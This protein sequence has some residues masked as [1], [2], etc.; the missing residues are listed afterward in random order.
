MLSVQFQISCSQ[1]HTWPRLSPLPLSTQVV[2]TLWLVLTTVTK[3]IQYWR[4]RSRGIKFQSQILCMLTQH[5]NLQWWHD[6]TG[7][8]KNRLR[9]L[10]LSAL[11]NSVSKP[12]Q[13][14][15][16]DVAFSLL[17]THTKQKNG[18]VISPYIY[19]CTYTPTCTCIH[20]YER[21][22]LKPSFATLSTFW[23]ART[24]TNLKGQASNWFLEIC[25]DQ[26][27]H[28]P[29]AASFS[30]TWPHV[31]T[32]VYEIRS[33]HCN[34]P[35]IRPQ[36]LYCCKSLTV[37]SEVTSFVWNEDISAQKKW[38]RVCCLY[39]KLWC[40]CHCLLKVPRDSWRWE[41]DLVGLF[42]HSTAR[43][44]FALPILPRVCFVWRIVYKDENH[45]WFKT[46]KKR[47]NHDKSS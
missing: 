3:H 34:T 1:P 31:S 45:A 16:S 23:S 37:T 29:P 18:A 20:I 30:P 42:A 11:W 13:L 44:Y 10:P 22:K 5:D 17:E 28:R 47:E 35:V 12:T 38:P 32:Y 4:T 33:V 26:I 27:A 39:S 36:L 2:A 46:K 43:S 41:D 21:Q 19:I 25:A 40:C 9:F 14:I 8:V 24:T 15:H 6:W 7:H